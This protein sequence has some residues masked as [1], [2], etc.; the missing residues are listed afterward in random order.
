MLHASFTGLARTSG[1]KHACEHVALDLP[2]L[3]TG[4]RLLAASFGWST[5]SNAREA[6]PAV[7]ASEES[8]LYSDLLGLLKGGGTTDVTFDFF[9]INAST[10]IKFQSLS[11]TRASVGRIDLQASDG[12]GPVTYLVTFVVPKGSGE[13]VTITGSTGAPNGSQRASF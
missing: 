8:S 4:T 2:P 1:V 10:T 5:R 3:R 9:K 6:T 7:P 11:L 13:W 12:A